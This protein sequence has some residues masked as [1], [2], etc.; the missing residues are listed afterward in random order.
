MRTYH[1][2]NVK[3]DILDDA[4]TQLQHAQDEMTVA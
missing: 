3:A 2:R 1:S 4:G